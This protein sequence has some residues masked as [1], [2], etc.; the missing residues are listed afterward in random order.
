MSAIRSPAL[1][2]SVCVEWRLLSASLC[3]QDMLIDS[4]AGITPTAGSTIVQMALA[5]LLTLAARIFGCWADYVAT[6]YGRCLPRPAVLSSARGLSNDSAAH[7]ADPQAYHAR[8]RKEKFVRTAVLKL[9]GGGVS[10]FQSTA[11]TC[12]QWIVVCH[13]SE[14]AS[15]GLWYAIAPKVVCTNYFGSGSASAS[16]SASASGSGSTSGSGSGFSAS[17]SSGFGSAGPQSS[18]GRVTARFGCFLSA[19]CSL[20][21]SMKCSRTHLSAGRTAGHVLA[22]GRWGRRPAAGQRKGGGASRATSVHRTGAAS[23]GPAGACP[24][25][26]PEE[27]MIRRGD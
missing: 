17:S 20:V 21:V 2:E 14:R 13:C 10:C 25:R 24:S 19:Y 15:S 7:S 9:R 11:R 5:P 22:G 26:A 3:R 6:G 8:G 4:L 18:Y 1:Q 12:E 16:A 23:A 27:M